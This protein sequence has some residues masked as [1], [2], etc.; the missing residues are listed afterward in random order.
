MERVSW[1]AEIRSSVE[2]GVTPVLRKLLQSTVV[3]PTAVTF[4]LLS[5]WNYNYH[6]ASGPSARSF[7]NPA[8]SRTGTPR[9][10]ALVSFEPG[11]FAS[12]EEVG[13]LRH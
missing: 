9:S 5:R 4:A 12:D 7:S 1:Y 3:Q 2:S 10:S 13:L 6:T 11:L 8:S